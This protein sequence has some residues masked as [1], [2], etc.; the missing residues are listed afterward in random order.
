MSEQ[1]DEWGPWIEHDGSGCPLPA[2]T[3]GEAKLR[4]GRVASFRACCG[5]TLG[6]PYV[7]ATASGSAWIWGS[8]VYTEQE[9]VRY[10]IRRPRGMAVLDKAMTDLP[11]EVEA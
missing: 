10:R 1:K 7:K 4:C 2:G 11:Q 9:V 3:L 6:G 8:S 5:S